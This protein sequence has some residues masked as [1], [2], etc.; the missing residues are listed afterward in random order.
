[1]T[2]VEQTR[3]DILYNRHLRVLKLRA[4]LPV[5]IHHEARPRR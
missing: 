1:M 3:S 4:P 5:R 2:P